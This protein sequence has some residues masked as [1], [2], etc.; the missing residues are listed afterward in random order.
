MH[1]RAK[2]VKLSFFKTPFVLASALF[3]CSAHSAG[4]AL[5][6]TSVSASIDW[7]SFKVIPIDT[8]LG[9][10]TLTWTDTTSGS[11]A[12]HNCYTSLS[13]N[14]TS[15]TNTATIGSF[16]QF[17]SSSTTVNKLMT[18][19]SYNNGFEYISDISGSANRRVAFKVHGDGSLLFQVNYTL[20]ISAEVDENPATSLSSEI[21]VSAISGSNYEAL[22][23]TDFDRTK[24]DTLELTTHNASLEESGV[25]SVAVDVKEGGSVAIFASAEV[26]RGV[27]PVVPLPA[28][29][30]LFG[31][32]LAGIAALRYLNV[33]R[34]KS[35]N[36]GRTGLIS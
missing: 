33:G 2:I 3:W 26:V 27:G 24:Y 21:E 10:P 34:L 1:Y 5:I 17:I 9:M 25:L 30:W 23:D 8:G 19:I 15:S 16:T 13:Q 14:D 12:G 6:S 31:S 18:S 4:A 11:C 36:H 28:A 20:T 32:A 22:I 35:I 29:V 7:N